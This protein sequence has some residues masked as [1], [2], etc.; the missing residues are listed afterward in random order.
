MSGHSSGAHLAAMLAMQD[1]PA[2]GIGPRAIRGIVCVSGAYDLEPVLLSSRRTYMHLSSR[3]AEALSP[4]GHVSDMR[5][6]VHVV[7]GTDESPEFIRQGRAFADALERCG[8]LAGRVEV[9]RN[10]FEIVDAMADPKHPLGRLVLDLL[11]RSEPSP[12]T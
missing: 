2:L 7:Y 10:H 12:S 11:R 1:W 4:I 5:I 6:P 8:K 3:E 9:D